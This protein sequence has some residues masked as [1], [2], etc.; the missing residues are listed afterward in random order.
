[1]NYV[2]LT[3]AGSAGKPFA[4]VVDELDAVLVTMPDVAD[5]R[6]MADSVRETIAVVPRPRV[7]VGASL[8]AMVALECARLGEADGLVLIAAGFGIRVADDVLE[9]VASNPPDLLAKNARIGLADPT[10]D[11]LAAIREEDFAA[12]GQPALLH[13]LQALAAYRP[14]PLSAPPPTVVLWGESDRGV[15]LADHTALAQRCRGVVVP[16]A[17]AGHAPFLEQPAETVRW[18]RWLGG[19]VAAGTFPEVISSQL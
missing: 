1:M 13:H 3:S 17:G 19:H 8:G 4:T 15:P 5:V 18:T 2:V 11:E 12:R 16:V 14:Q 9:W 6:E 7:L 10:D